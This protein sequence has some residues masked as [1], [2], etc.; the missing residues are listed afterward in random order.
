MAQAFA[1]D[2]PL[3]LSSRACRPRFV[4][5]EDNSSG[6]GSR[7]HAQIMSDVAARIDAVRNQRDCLL[8]RF[9]RRFRRDILPRHG[10]ARSSASSRRPLPAAHWCSPAC[11]SR[12]ERGGK[13]PARPRPASIAALVSISPCPRHRRDSRGW[14]RCVCRRGNRPCADARL[15]PRRGARALRGE[16]DWPTSRARFAGSHRPLR[17]GLQQF[18][19]LLPVELRIAGREM[20][21]RLAGGRDQ[22]QAAV[23]DAL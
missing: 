6:G 19:H 23:L 10:R 1:S 3:R 7:M 14:R 20:A 5:P 17:R 22:E 15:R 21:A 16:N 18:L 13:F 8:R 4:I 2:P 11:P 9:R 12:P